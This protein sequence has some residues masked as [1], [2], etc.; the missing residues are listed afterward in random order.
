[1]WARIDLAKWIEEASNVFGPY[2]KGE[3]DGLVA[4]GARLRSAG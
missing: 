2:Q 3:L 1:M 4:E